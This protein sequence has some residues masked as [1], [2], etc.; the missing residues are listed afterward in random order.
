LSEQKAAGRE[1]S[2]EKKVGVLIMAY[3]TPRGPD[4]VE[5]FYTDV[6]RGRPP[7]L[8]QL[9]ELRDRYL[10]VGGASQLARVSAKQAEGIQASLDA[11]APGRFLCRFAAKH[12]SPRIEETVAELA[13][14]G[15]AGICGLVLAP[16]YSSASVGQYLERAREESAAH[17]LSSAFVIDWHDNPVLVS[18]LAE[19]VAASLDE[20]ITS[21]ADE[22]FELLVT[23]H[24]L[25]LRVI[26]SGDGYDVRLHE[27]AELVARA[28]S[29]ERWRVCWQSAGRT[30]EPWIGPDLNSVLRSLPGEGVKSV[31]VCPAGFTSDHLEIN[32]DID[33][34]ARAVSEEVGLRLARTS[35]LNAEP[36]LCAELARLI[37]RSAET[38]VPVS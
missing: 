32:Y 18:L 33:I 24:S 16:H 4:D 37:S 34:E 10:A 2:P 6:R 3:G 22:S 30:S 31:L 38:I 36:R 28:S 19:R 17:G 11:A 13:G 7:S 26:E 35:S 14:A 27:T 9:A 23:A 5:A 21:P 15:V 20:L 1:G 25:P 12:S 8:E 29:V